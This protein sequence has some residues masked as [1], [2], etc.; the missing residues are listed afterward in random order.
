MSSDSEISFNDSDSGDELFGEQPLEKDWEDLDED[1]RSAALLLGYVDAQWPC[2][3]R[4]WPEW[5]DLEEELQEAAGVLGLDEDSW[6]PKQDV[7]R[8]DWGDLDAD[9]QAAAKQLGY[10]DG[11]WPA[12]SRS[13][14]DWE[15][16]SEAEQAA[17]EALGM[18]EYSWPP[19]SDDW[20]PE[21][22]FASAEIEEEGEEGCDPEKVLE[23]Y[24]R[25]IEKEGATDGPDEWGFRA[26]SR[27]VCLECARGNFD[28]M[29]VAYKM[30]IGDDYRRVTTR[31]KQEEIERV[32]GVAGKVSSK[33]DGGR[34][35]EVLLQVF[36]TTLSMFSAQPRIWVQTQLKLAEVCRR[37]GE[38]GQVEQACRAIHGRTQKSAGTKEELA[39]GLPS[40]GA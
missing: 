20:E 13:W 9:Q 28:E 29:I 24:R 22:L 35:D 10:T 38:W 19:E 1:E 11:T 12:C 39:R 16:L 30:M 21:D 33:G 17:A 27:I 23:M 40:E 37:K 26:Y 6:P 34:G 31:L 7:F 2:T 14:P 36:E 3:E 18:D 32:L 8:K 15:D 5:D 25:V 4:E